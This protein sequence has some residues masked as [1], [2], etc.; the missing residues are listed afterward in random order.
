MPSVIDDIDKI[1]QRGAKFTVEVD[2]FRNAVASVFADHPND[3]GGK[4]I[5]EL[6]GY[7]DLDYLLFDSW[8]AFGFS[9]GVMGDESLRIFRWL[10]FNVSVD[11][12]DKVFFTKFDSVQDISFRLSS[13]VFSEPDSKKNTGAAM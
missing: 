2:T 8:E 5:S 9:G 4:S 11:Y 10:Q 7:D 6:V 12:A 1:I 3:L 13:A